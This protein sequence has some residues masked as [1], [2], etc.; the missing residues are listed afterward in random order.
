MIR[1]KPENEILLYL[2]DKFSE[3]E[4]FNETYRENA[5]IA[6]NF[7]DGNQWTKQELEVFK[8]RK[9]P[10]LVF[11]RIKP[12][13]NT[14]TSLQKGNRSDISYKPQDSSKWDYMAAKLFTAIVKQDMK[15][16]NYHQ[17]ESRAF[18]DY[19]VT[20]RGAIQLYYNE[21]L[22]R[23]DIEY[24]DFRNF[25][26]D[27]SSK[28]DDLRDA[29]YVHIAQYMSLEEAKLLF[30]DEA[31]GGTYPNESDDSVIGIA[32]RARVVQTWVRVPVRKADGSWENQYD[33]IVWQD[34]KILAYYE[35]PYP[36]ARR[37]PVVQMTLY[38]DLDNVP[39]GVVRDLIDVQRTLNYTRSK[40]T[41]ILNTN[42]YVYRKGA[43]DGS[44][45]Q[46]AEALSRPDSVIP[47][48]L[49]GQ[50]IA[51]ISP[52][53]DLAALLNIMNEAKREIPE[54]AGLADEI[55]ATN[56]KVMSGKAIALRQQSGLAR[57]TEI[58]DGL[59]HFKAEVG[60][61]A[62]GIIRDYYDIG[63]ISRLVAAGGELSDE[64]VAQI[65]QI[66]QKIS[67]DKTIEFDI[68]H[69]VDPVTISQQEESYNN[70]LQIFSINPQAIPI[71]ALIQASNWSNKDE[72][73]QI[74]QQ[75]NQKNAVLAQ[76]Q[77]QLK[78][79]Q[80]A[81]TRLQKEAEAKMNELRE[82]L[83]K[84]DET[85]LKLMEKLGVSILNNNQNIV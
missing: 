33:C 17:I 24:I 13:I 77:Q 32:E 69:G 75:A 57:L 38:R 4:T 39:Y 28:Y 22:K 43:F 83:E 8:K 84:K 70:L 79:M 82:Q 2:G 56:D 5:Q 42:K 78:S 34:G 49:G 16:A 37:F 55:L 15:K 27:P 21:D 61:M 72:I 64:E 85:I 63:R 19:V 1:G 11:N 14:I 31:G 66:W 40:A 45:A 71:E 30:G 18:F 26:P 41:H 73:L 81:L 20:G 9:Q 25:Y 36:S 48:E 54:I 3:A 53:G 10:P 59:K 35:N 51:D 80:E 46:L 7:Y 62:L 67:N 52:K 12:T 74:I 60:R 23:L 50:D 76:Q 29:E 6:V 47:L 65:A 44:D 68:V 58:F